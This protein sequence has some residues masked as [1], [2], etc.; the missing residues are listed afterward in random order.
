MC[1]DFQFIRIE[2]MELLFVF[3][4]QLVYGEYSSIL[5]YIANVP[6]FRN[7]TVTRALLS[8]PHIF[9]IDILLTFL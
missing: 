4:K 3:P 7:H 2:G 1:G 9:K 6:M 5:Y 8:I